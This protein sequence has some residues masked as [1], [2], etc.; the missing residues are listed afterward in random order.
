MSGVCNVY[1]FPRSRRELHRYTHQARRAG[2][3]SPALAASVSLAS[4]SA[5]TSPSMIDGGSAGCLVWL[6]G[7]FG[8]LGGGVPLAH[9]ALPA[10]RVGVDGSVAAA[11]PVS[12][13][14]VQKR[15]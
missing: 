15:H 13:A 7:R 14:S 5:C 9:G 11:F 10:A 12:F 2:G 1:V 4:L 8:W 3:P 6:R